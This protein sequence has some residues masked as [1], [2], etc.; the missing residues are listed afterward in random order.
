MSGSNASVQ[1]NAVDLLN[2]HQGFAVGNTSGSNFVINQL[3]EG[4]WTSNTFSLS[5]ITS[6]NLKGVSAVSSQDAWAV[7][8]L[9][10]TTT[11]LLQWNGSSWSNHANTGT[12]S[13]LN[14]VQVLDTSGNGIGNFGFAVGQANGGDSGSSCSTDFYQCYAATANAADLAT[15][16]NYI[17]T[18]SCYTVTS[19][20]KK[21]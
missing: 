19:T 13:N 17:T 10:S 6:Q 1:F 4:T 11:L 15:C 20:K 5:G 7:G 8:N 18:N 12:D 2:A 16:Q 14:A 3:N 9:D 21:V